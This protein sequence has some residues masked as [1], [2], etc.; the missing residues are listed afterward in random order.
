MDRLKCGP[1]QTKRLIADLVERG[2]IERI[3][4]GMIERGELEPLKIPLKVGRKP[5]YRITDAGHRLA[6]KSMLKRIPRAKAEQIVADLIE[7]AKA[8]NARPE[9]L[10]GV[11]EILAFGSYVGDAATV[12]DIDVALTYHR[13]ADGK[14][15]GR[16]NDERVEATASDS[17][18]RDFMKSLRWGHDEVK[19]LLKARNRYLQFAAV[20]VLEQ[21]HFKDA[22]TRVIFSAKPEDIAVPAWCTR[23]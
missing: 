10:Y 23:R 9:L 4:S 11:T 22:Q 13:K 5:T 19:Q 16:W 15:A 17:V 20:D 1:A 6:A 21:A 18:Q 8:I 14:E 2:L 3:K 12:G 7:R